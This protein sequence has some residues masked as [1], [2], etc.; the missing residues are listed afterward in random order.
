MKKISIFILAALYQVCLLNGQKNDSV[1]QYYQ[2]IET[3]QLKIVASKY[4]SALFTYKSAMNYM[5]LYNKD[6][7]NALLCALKCKRYKDAVLFASQLVEKGVPVSFFNKSEKT[8]ILTLQKEWKDYLKTN[9]A[10]KYNAD[11]R[12]RL[13]QLL[14]L[15]QKFRG[16]NLKYRDSIR[17]TDDY[18]CKEIS[19][20]FDQYGYPSEK[21]IGVWV[22]NDTLIDVSWNPLDIIL[23]HQIKRD[24]TRFVDFLEKSVYNG[25]MKNSV[26][27]MHTVNFLPGDRYLFRCMQ[28]GN[29]DVIRVG[30]DLYTCCCIKVQLINA[31]RERYFLSSLDYDLSLMNYRLAKG[32]YFKLGSTPSFYPDVTNPVEVAKLIRDLK[33]QGFILYK[34]LYP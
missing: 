2:L 29:T 31:N 5:D 1:R 12:N 30:N 14:V 18:I 23:I 17:Q 34:S 16:D 22:A 28:S 26:F 32:G 20:I 10:A 8:K 13:E 27:S 6:S 21:L 19:A 9:P 24:P 3:A 4:D 15:D 7:Y 11:L 25:S 33:E